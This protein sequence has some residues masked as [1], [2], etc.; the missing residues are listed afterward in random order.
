M[1]TNWIIYQGRQWW[2]HRTRPLHSWG[3]RCGVSWAR[4]GS[5]SWA[6]SSA[7]ESSF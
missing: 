1:L 4:G 7:T 3:L 5:W 6:S 2:Q